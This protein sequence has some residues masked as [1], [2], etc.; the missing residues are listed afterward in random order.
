ML[1]RLRM[2]TADCKRWYLDISKDAF[3]PVI[4]RFNPINWWSAGASF[5]GKRLEDA[6]HR[7]VLSALPEGSKLH[8]DPEFNQGLKEKP[9]PQESLLKIPS[10]LEESCKV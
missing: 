5:D 10:G 3:T 2:S 8:N 4:S 9:D 1:G 7:I 6:I